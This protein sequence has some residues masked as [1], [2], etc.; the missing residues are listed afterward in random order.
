[1]VTVLVDN[2]PEDVFVDEPPASPPLFSP[3]DSTDS[4][5]TELLSAAP[6][7]TYPGS[8]VVMELLHT[9][10]KYVQDLETMQVRDSRSLVSTSVFTLDSLCSDMRLQPLK[11]TQLIKTQY[12]YYS[13][14]S[15]SCS[16]S[17][18]DF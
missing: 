5:P 17:S 4:L 13:P 7:D 1:M 15:T 18:G 11:Q 9:E 12:T 16:T 10:R 6:K 2:L 8:Q 3:K 14:A